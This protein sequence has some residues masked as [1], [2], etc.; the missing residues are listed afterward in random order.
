MYPISSLVVVVVVLF[1]STH[2]YLPTAAITPG[3]LRHAG[4][5]LMLCGRLEAQGREEFTGSSHH[6]VPTTGQRTLA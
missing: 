6:N 4:E 2:F 1:F 5:C 3:E